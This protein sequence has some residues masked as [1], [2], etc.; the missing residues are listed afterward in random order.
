[1]RRKFFSVLIALVLALSL[2][3]IPATPVAASP[4]TLNVRPFTLQTG[5]N[6][7]A[8]STTQKATGS[9]SVLLSYA[10]GDSSYVEFT[11]LTGTT[12][13]DLDDI[14][15]GWSWWYYFPAADGYGPLLELRFTGGSGHVDITVDTAEATHTH[16]AG[17][18]VEVTNASSCI[19]YG[20]DPA[21][22]T[23]FDDVTSSLTLAGVLAAINAETAM[24]DGNDVATA[25][26]L[27]RVRVEI[28]WSGSART[29]YID[30]IEINSVI[31]YGK[32]DDAVDSASA[33][34]TIQVYPGTYAED[35]SVG[36]ASLTLES[37]AG[38]A[39]TFIEGEMTLNAAADTFILGGA[40]GKGFTLQGSATLVR[41]ASGASDVT[42]SYN[43]FDLTDGTASKGILIQTAASC[44]GWT[45]TENAFT[46]TDIQDQG[47]Y[48]AMECIIS[49][50][51]VSNNTFT[52]TSNLLETSG[53]EICSPDITSE[54]TTI[55]GNT[56]TATEKGVVIGRDQTA[57]GLVT[58]T[59]ATGTLTI[60]GNTFDGL[61]WGLEI[62]NAHTASDTDQDVDITENTFSSNEYAFTIDYGKYPMGA[63][64]LEPGDFTVDFND[65]SGNTY[66][67]YNNVAASVTAVNNWWGDASGPGTVGPGTG[68]SVSERVDYNPG[69]TVTQGT[70]PRAYGYYVG[71]AEDYTTIQAGI[72]AAST[73][74]TIVVADGTYTEG[75]VDVDKG[76][77]L[78][79]TGGASACTIKVDAYGF[80]VIA[81]DVTIDGFT[82][83][84]S[85]NPTTT[86]IGLLR[87]GM[88]TTNAK[89]AADNVTIQNNIFKDFV[90]S[91]ATEAHHGVAVGHSDISKA[92]TDITITNNTF[93]NL[94]TTVSGR[95]MNAVI[96]F[97]DSAGDARAKGVT[98]SNNT[99]HDIKGT[100]SS[101]ANGIAIEAGGS[102]TNE[103]VT[104]DSNTIYN[105]SGGLL[106][107]GIV[108][109]D[110]SLAVNVTGNEIYN[111]TY[112]MLIDATITVTQ[113]DIHDND[114]GIRIFAGG[115]GA[116]INY[117]DIYDNTS[118]G[119][120]NDTS[121]NV[122]AKY[123]YWG[124]PSGP[125]VTTNA[126]GTGDTVTVT[127]VTYEPWLHTTQAT[128]YPSG[129]RYYAYNWCDLTKGWN[130]WS[131]PIALD[132]A[133][134][135]WG[136]YKA[137]GTDLDLASGSS[138]YYFNGS[139]QAW[140]S[141]T[142]NYTLTPCDAIYVKVASTEEAPILFSP[143]TSA[144]SKTVYVGWNLVSASYIDDMDTPYVLN[145]VAPET[146]LAS[147]YYVPGPY[148]IGYS[149]VVSPATGQTGWI[150]SRGAAID[151]SIGS[152]VMLPCKGY[153]VYMTNG[154]GT[155]AGAVFTPVSPLQ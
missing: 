101:W 128:V 68:D 118:F 84:A 86:G 52:G 139:T 45:V 65:F 125:T 115:P 82:F 149:Q 100:G 144:P 12:V 15:G 3:L 150:N 96:C 17:T 138:V 71:S 106:N 94:E 155:L 39:T 116:T 70:S 43:T 18:T 57:A 24:T 42:I 59:S 48:G 49:E 26:E 76:L 102:G 28:G 112:G 74:D 21:D 64:Y 146:A 107:I 108:V 109:Y 16:D 78:Q 98:I 58:G 72:D 83:T 152:A 81:D 122:D 69:L 123:N 67:I 60:S 46:I 134:D 103:G 61:K 1:M 44:S 136:E 25:W 145:G 51:T 111:G 151:T 56:I 142:D 41:N 6:A 73:G 90:T 105:L 119:I 32:I 40:T 14:S 124:D 95:W 91:Q 34:D 93:Q 133:A 110:N 137:L 127:Y 22:Q 89:Y 54:S 31:Y 9:S 97:D 30:D 121:T 47:I 23:S 2:S 77:I 135:T 80:C 126:R 88:S 141:V 62:I 37:T 85:S 38:M 29:C 147:V 53:I 140:A 19:Y 5:T 36:T 75:Q 148:N 11:P 99:I 35:V 154:G 143:S 132:A 55:S 8:W 20:N 4:G 7:A 113:N 92:L 13:A 63:D 129:V 114:S 79:S 33:S 50:L 153:W 10:S 66:A 104:I 120:T 27:T 87:V 117:N 130:I 131:T